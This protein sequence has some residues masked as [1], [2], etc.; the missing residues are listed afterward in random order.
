[1]KY[2]PIEE[3][4]VG[5][6]A[7]SQWLAQTWRT[8]SFPEVPREAVIVSQNRAGLEVKPLKLTEKTCVLPFRVTK[9]GDFDE[10]VEFRSESKHLILKCRFRGT[11][12]ETIDLDLSS[13]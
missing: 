8:A 6:I 2:Q 13:R 10:T 5:K 9:A 7:V 12:R 3:N 11:S 1:M 4:D